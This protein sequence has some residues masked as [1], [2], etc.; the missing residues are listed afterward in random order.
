LELRRATKESQAAE[1]SYDSLTIR[2]DRLRASYRTLNEEERNNEEVGGALL[3]SIK[4]Y[5]SKLKDLDKSM[6]IN[7]RNV[8][9]YSEE[10]Q[11]ALEKN[12]NI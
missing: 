3:A 1:G 8:G 9:N 7:N 11:K 5:D 12:R 2:L 4:E 6:G 10:V